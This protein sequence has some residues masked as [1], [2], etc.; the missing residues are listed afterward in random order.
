M[1]AQDPAP[2][3]EPQPQSEPNSSNSGYNKNSSF[4]SSFFDNFFIGGDFGAQF[5]NQTYVE[6]AP[7]FGYHLTD[8]FSAG[9]TTKYIYYSYKDAYSPEKYQTSL[10]GGGLFT[11]YNVT[12]ELFAHAEYE[13]LSVEIPA[14]YL[15]KRRIVS[16]LFLGGGYRQFIGENSSINLMMLFNVIHEQFSLYQNPVIRVGF[17]FGF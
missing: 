10:Y 1:F 11:R 12:E 13:A 9:I 6:V 3:P 5:G 14:I 7:R 2:S 17:D 4:G 16:S 8:L 15:D